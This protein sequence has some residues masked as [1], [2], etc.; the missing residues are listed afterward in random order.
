MKPAFLSCIALAAAAVL[1][2]CAVHTEQE[3]AAIRASGV[4]PST[5][6]KMS[7]R[8]ILTPYDIVELRKRRVDD[9]LVITHLEKVSVNY[10]L[11]KDD[12]KTMKTAGVRQAVISAAVR[13]SSRFLAYASAP[14]NYYFSFGYW[15]DPFW[16]PYYPRYWGGYYPYWGGYGPRWGYGQRWGYGYRCWR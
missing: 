16:G 10:V 15:N 1:A 11:Q 6:R 4:A 14:S 7:G 9:A 8:G 12:V 2:G 13:A 5:L 3:I